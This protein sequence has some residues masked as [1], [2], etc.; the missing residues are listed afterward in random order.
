MR[1]APL[2]FLTLFFYGCASAPPSVKIIEQVTKNEDAIEEIEES[3]LPAQVKAR[4]VAAIRD[5][6]KLAVQSSEA[7][8]TCAASLADAQAARWRWAG[9]GAALGAMLGFFLGRKS[10]V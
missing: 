10:P 7:Y 4:T 9:I 2:I 8:E 1:Y 5:T 3:D 6:Q